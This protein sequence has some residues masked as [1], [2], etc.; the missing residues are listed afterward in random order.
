MALDLRGVVFTRSYSVILEIVKN[1]ITP[2]N[3]V[4]LQ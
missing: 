4:E 2:T 1:L 3:Y